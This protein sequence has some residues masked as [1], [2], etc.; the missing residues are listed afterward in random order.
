MIRIELHPVTQIINLMSIV[1]LKTE[2]HSRHSGSHRSVLLVLKK[3]WYEPRCNCLV[4]CRSLCLEKICSRHHRLDTPS[5]LILYWEWSQ[6]YPSNSKL[7]TLDCPH[8]HQQCVHVDALASTA[9]YAHRHTHQSF[10]KMH[11]FSVRRATLSML[12]F[13]TNF[14]LLHVQVLSVSSLGVSSLWLGVTSLW[15]PSPQPNNYGRWNF[16]TTWLSLILKML[17]HF[18]SKFWMI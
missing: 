1:L 5:M 14:S 12:S 9:L 7:S 4:S 11:L 15:L 8:W 2:S 3:K 6:D 17:R 10:I 13:A 18:T 16:N